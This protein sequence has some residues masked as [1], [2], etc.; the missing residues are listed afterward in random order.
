MAVL[1]FSF[2]GATGGD[3]F[4]WAHTTNTFA[5]NYGVCNVILTSGGLILNFLGA[6]RGPEI[7]LEGRGPLETAPVDA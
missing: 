6:T 4:I 1:G 2:W 3:T 5:L 7:L